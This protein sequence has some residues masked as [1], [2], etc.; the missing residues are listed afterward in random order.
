M[1]QS[2]MYVV[3]FVIA[4]TTHLIANIQQLTVVTEQIR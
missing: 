1:S 3:A 4:L 2:E